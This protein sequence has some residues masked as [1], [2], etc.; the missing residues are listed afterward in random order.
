M[1]LSR[2]SIGLG[3]EEVEGLPALDTKGLNGRVPT[4]EAVTIVAASRDTPRQSRIVMIAL[5]SL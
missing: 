4:T 5:R 1:Q 2:D 3:R